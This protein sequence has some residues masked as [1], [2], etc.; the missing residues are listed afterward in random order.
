MSNESVLELYNL[1]IS[2]CCAAVLCSDGTT[3]FERRAIIAI[4]TEIIPRLEANR[5]SMERESVTPMQDLAN[6]CADLTLACNTV[7][8]A[9]NGSNEEE[10]NIVS[11]AKEIL[12]SLEAILNRAGV[13]IKIPIAQYG[14]PIPTLEE[15]NPTYSR[16]S[17]TGSGGG[18]CY[19]ATA[20]YGSYNCPQVW[21]LRRFRDGKLAK[22]VVGRLFIK[23]YYGISPKLVKSLGRY[24]LF[25]KINRSWLDRFVLKLQREGYSD[26]PYID[27]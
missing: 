27:K 9:L 11:N 4:S 14:K 1:A 26:Q 7:I 19:I 6:G 21:V 8:S 3:E 22:S 17:Q 20:A 5:R 25:N 24:N 2:V 13:S 16:S 23:C 18:G 15:A 12:K 10:R